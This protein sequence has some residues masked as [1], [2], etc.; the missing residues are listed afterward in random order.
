MPRTILD[1]GGRQIGQTGGRI[2]S[3]H[4]YYN[5]EEGQCRLPLGLVLFRLVAPPLQP[6]VVRPCP[7]RGVCFPGHLLLEGTSRIKF[8]PEPA[9][10]GTWCTRP[11]QCAL[12]F[13]TDLIPDVTTPS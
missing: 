10:H 13:D 1:R 3:V 2:L 12:N 8:G 7:V 6:G 9:A 11:R 5:E 4:I